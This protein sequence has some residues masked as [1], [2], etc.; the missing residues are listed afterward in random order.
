MYPRGSSFLSPILK[1][2]TP[3]SIYRWFEDNGVPLKV[4]KDMR[5]FPVSND[6][7]D[8]VGVFEYMFHENNRHIDTI[9]RTKVESVTQAVCSDGSCSDRFQVITDK[10]GILTSSNVVIATGG[11]AYRHTGSSGDGY[12]FAQSL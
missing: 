9:L 12:A 1:A 11:Q 6:G 10:S 8:I 3:K 4:E 7:H 5:V 2:F